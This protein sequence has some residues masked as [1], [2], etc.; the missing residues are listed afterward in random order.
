MATIT[1][2]DNGNWTAKIRRTGF[3][4]IS[5]TFKRKVDAQAWARDIESERNPHVVRSQKEADRTTLHAALQRYLDEETPRKKGAK[6]ER[7]RILAWQRNPLAKCYLSTLTGSDFAKYRDQRAKEGAAA[8]TIRNDLNTISVVFNQA[9]TE[10]GMVSL[11]NP[12]QFV[13]RPSPGHGRDRRLVGDEETQLI[14][15][16]GHPLKQMIILALETAMRMGE[17]LSL[18]WANIDLKKQ[19]VTL[20]DTKNGERRVVPLSTRA[21][22]A[23]KDYYAAEAKKRLATS[24]G[25]ANPRPVQNFAQAG[26]ARDQAGAQFGVFPA[27]TNSAISHQFRDLCE[28][29]KIKGLRFHDLRHEG[30]SRLFEKGFNPMEVAAITGHKTLIMLK[31]YTHLKAEDLAKRLG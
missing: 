30:T 15:N 25:G 28:A 10:W 24:T 31:R 29:Q 22:A 9:R 11:S 16:A 2:R 3:P 13:K 1:K 21:V 23:L 4:P 27:V 26:K 5:K 18:E 14:D 17:I 6:A 7:N 8:S 20:E 19:T 12:I